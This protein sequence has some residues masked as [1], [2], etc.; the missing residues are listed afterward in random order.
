MLERVTGLP[1]GVDGL[2]AKGKITRE[3]Y[4]LVLQ[5]ILE[6]A[7]SQG[8]ASSASE[9]QDALAWLSTPTA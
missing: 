3:D 6:D 9:W 8:G 7:R 5:S 2:R 4:D 1:G